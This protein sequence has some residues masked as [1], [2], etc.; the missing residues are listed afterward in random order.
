MIQSSSALGERLDMSIFVTM[1]VV[2]MGV[3][4]VIAHGYEFGSW[5][6]SQTHRRKGYLS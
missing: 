6:G 1:S 3:E 4:N 5:R 2:S